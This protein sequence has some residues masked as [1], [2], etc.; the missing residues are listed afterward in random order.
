MSWWVASITLDLSGSRMV[1][2]DPVLFSLME[3]VL[4]PFEESSCHGNDFFERRDL[5]AGVCACLLLAAKIQFHRDALTG[6]FVT[7]TVCFLASSIILFAEAAT[8]LS[9]F[10]L[11]Q[12]RNYISFSTQPWQ[13]QQPKIQWQ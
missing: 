6:S 4:H 3:F 12:Q 10:P 1:V 13:K 9:L 2:L 7:D 11:L 8:T 5:F